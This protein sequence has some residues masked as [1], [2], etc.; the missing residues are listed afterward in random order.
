MTTT[1][2]YK[3]AV[4]IPLA[5]VQIFCTTRWMRLPPRP[6]RTSRLLWSSTAILIT[7]KLC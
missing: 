2:R 6:R 1:Y 5:V 4:I 7:A 3:A